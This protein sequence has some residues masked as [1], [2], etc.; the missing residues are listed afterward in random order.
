V[1]NAGSSMIALSSRSSFV[2]GLRLDWLDEE[3]SLPHRSVAGR[4]NR[5]AVQAVS[6]K[7]RWVN[8]A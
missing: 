4:F 3:A 2:S 5:L 1:V 8:E 7:S 6:V